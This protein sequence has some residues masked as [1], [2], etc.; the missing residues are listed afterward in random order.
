MAGPENPR[1]AE[2]GH[3]VGRSKIM[4]AAD[5]DARYAE[6][7]QWSVEPNV[8]FAEA[9]DALAEA[10][11][12]GGRA[13]D[14]AC[15]EGRNAVWLAERGWDVT[16]VDFSPAGVERGRLGGLERSIEV[17]WQ[18]ADLATWDLGRERWDLVAHV[19]LHWGPGE[20]N[21]FLVRCAGA[22]ASGGALVVVGH[23]RSNIDHGYGG[24]QN[25]DLLTTPEE[26]SQG[27]T[28]AGLTVTRAELVYREVEIV[29]DDGASSTARA[30]DHVVVA[31]R[32]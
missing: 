30:I 26:L 3:G 22:V 11:L 25:P 10:G 31:R 20:R 21:P 19:Y 14:L 4:T 12:V 15:G 18:V 24:P 1:R 29:D 6:G 16:A 9:V 2:T 13:V 32:L 17:D 28:Q 7:R 5:W 23:D 27:F 8:F